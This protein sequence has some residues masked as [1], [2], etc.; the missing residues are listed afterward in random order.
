[1]EKLSG[2]RFLQSGRALAYAI[3]PL[4]VLLAVISALAALLLW[5]ATASPEVLVF[6]G[7]LVLFVLPVVTAIFV[8]R[9]I[10]KFISSRQV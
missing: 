5:P 2:A 7:F 6:A 9:W 4:A 3:A 8:I 10:G 1:M